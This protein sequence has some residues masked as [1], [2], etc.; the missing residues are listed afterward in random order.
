MLFL[1]IFFIVAIMSNE[2]TKVP[3][4]IDMTY[5]FTWDSEPSDEQLETLMQAVGEEVR[6]RRT[7]ADQKNREMRK[8][9][10]QRAIKERELRRAEMQR[11]NEERRA[12]MFGR[13]RNAGNTND[14]KNG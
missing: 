7:T 6:R 14:K 13:N 3:V 4:P 9:E 12:A 2:N 1:R 8:A 10:M 5:R 11:T